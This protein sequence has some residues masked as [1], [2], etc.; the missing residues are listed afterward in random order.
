M[1]NY[2]KL[3]S[4][5]RSIF[6]AQNRTFST[7]TTAYN[8]KIVNEAINPKPGRLYRSVPRLF[9]IAALMLAVPLAATYYDNEQ[10]KKELELRN[11]PGYRY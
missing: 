10:F 11:Q 8:P 4:I 9:F 5:S 3:Y 7:N 6:K 2:T 1:R